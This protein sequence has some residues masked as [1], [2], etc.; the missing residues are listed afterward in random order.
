MS[1]PVKTE[2]DPTTNP[3]GDDPGDQDDP[4][5]SPEPGAQGDK[6]G[7]GDPDPGDKGSKKGDNT[8]DPGDDGDDDLTLDDAKKLIKK[9]RGENANSRTKNKGLEERLGK[10]EKGLKSMFGEEDDDDDR[11]PE[12]KLADAQAQNESVAF[13]NAMLEFCLDNG[14]TDKSDRKYLSY[15][16]AEASEELDEGEELSEEKLAELVQEAKSRGKGS[17]SKKANSSAD[18]GDGNDNPSPDGD[19]EVTLDQFA[20]MSV[21][22]KNE[23]YRNHP[24]TYKKLWAQAKEKGLV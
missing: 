9:L 4:G 5:N 6:G 7:D 2:D 15:L 23:L 10:I 8:D 1:K 17:G 20:E 11:S 14:I 13:Q 24:D 16:V 22:D 21:L 19:S 3:T 18:S 12:D